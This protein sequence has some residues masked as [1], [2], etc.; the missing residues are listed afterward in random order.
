MKVK[1]VLQRV[2]RA[3]GRVTMKAG[4]LFGKALY[5]FSKGAVK[6]V[7]DAYHELKQEKIK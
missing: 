1:P 3:T 2:G 6:G 4:G 5:L 7:Q